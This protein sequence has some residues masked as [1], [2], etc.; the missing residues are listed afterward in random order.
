MDILSEQAIAEIA[1]SWI[2]CNCQGLL[3][4]LKPADKHTPQHKLCGKI[5]KMCLD[6]I[7]AVKLTDMLGHRNWSISYCNECEQ[8]IYKG[9]T[10]NDGVILCEPCIEKL[11]KEITMWD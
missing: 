5:D 3:A 4:H 11:Y 10:L 7:T 6:E 1:F 2:K 9:M 8:K